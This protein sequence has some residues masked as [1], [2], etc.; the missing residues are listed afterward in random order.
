MIKEIKIIISIP[1]NSVASQNSA[2]TI[3]A[4][5]KWLLIKYLTIGLFISN[6]CSI[7]KDDSIVKERRNTVKY[8][9]A[10]R[11]AKATCQ[12]R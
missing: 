6:I 3:K 11:K 1:L 8:T 10:A 2:I 5:R 9:Y 7:R 4:A 12:H